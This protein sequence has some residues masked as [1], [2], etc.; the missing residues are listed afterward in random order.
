MSGKNVAFTRARAL[1]PKTE[2]DLSETRRVPV[3]DIA[4][5][6]ARH[7]LYHGQRR[8]RCDG[9]INCVPGRQKN[10]HSGLSRNRMGGRADVARRQRN[11]RSGIRILRIERHEF[12]RYRLECRAALGRR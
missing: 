2:K 9:R 12:F 1:L 6:P 11:A 4:A 10:A 3:Q 7:G 5:R 8:G